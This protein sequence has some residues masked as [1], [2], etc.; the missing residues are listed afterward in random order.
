[1]SK[2]FTRESESEIQEWVR[3]LSDFTLPPG[4]KNYMTPAG[5]RRFREEL[6]RLIEIDRPRA[7]NSSDSK[8]EL[9]GIDQRIARLQH[10]LGLAE[11]VPPPET[12]DE[13][14]RF[15]ATVTVRDS[16]GGTSEYRIVG[17]DEIDVDRDWISWRSPVAK[18]LL[19]KKV[20]DKVRFVVPD[21]ER[22]LQI[23]QI[24]YDKE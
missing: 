14:V 16:I 1:M 11:I 9:T 5:A 21:G 8:G 10:S 12:C 17:I 15:G 19:N 23:A 18:A 4:V 3:P 13:S 7:V 2:A 22:H 24:R 6:K 20:G